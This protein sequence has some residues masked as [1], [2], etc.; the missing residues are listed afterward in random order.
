MRY[1][2]RNIW[3]TNFLGYL[4]LV[5]GI[6]GTVIDF[7]SRFQFS[8]PLDMGIVLGNGAIAAAGL[9]ATMLVKSLREL[10]RRLETIEN[11]TRSSM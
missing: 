8:F 5:C 10:G 7:V 11:M 6:A 2:M 4:F 9:L 3:A 1:D